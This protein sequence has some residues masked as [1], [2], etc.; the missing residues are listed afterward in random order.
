M[1][2]SAVMLKGITSVI[3]RTTAAS[4]RARTAFASKLSGIVSDALERGSGDGSHI[5]MPMST[6][7]RMKKPR[8]KH[9]ECVPF[10]SHL[11]LQHSFQIFL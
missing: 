5:T 1:I 11:L 10:L 6:K 7:A 4:S 8:L 9:S 2:R 3:Q